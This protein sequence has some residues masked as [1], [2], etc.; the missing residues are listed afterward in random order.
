MFYDYRCY[1]TD[2]KINKS[3]CKYPLF[4]LLRLPKYLELAT[5]LTNLSPLITRL[6]NIKYP[7]FM[8]AKQEKC[9]HRYQDK[10]NHRYFG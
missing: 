8:R 6:K 4:I 7:K 9:L 2:S 3:Q 5:T 10:R 1:R